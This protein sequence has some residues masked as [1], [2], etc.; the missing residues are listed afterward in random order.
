MVVYHGAIGMVLRIPCSKHSSIVDDRDRSELVIGDL[1]A[2]ES[3]LRSIAATR[4][5]RAADTDDREEAC[6]RVL[7]GLLHVLAEVMH[8]NR[9][10]VRVDRWGPHWLQRVPDGMPRVQWSKLL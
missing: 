6:G 5:Q 4:Q 8:P 9:F 3:I 2:A 1:N 10:S 7:G